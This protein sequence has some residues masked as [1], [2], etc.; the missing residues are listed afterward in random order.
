MLQVAIGVMVYNEAANLESLLSS[1]RRVR[2]PRLTLQQIV[3]VSSGSVDRSVPIA[4]EAA[5]RDARITVV[6]DP[7][8]RGKATAVNQFLDA[9]E[10][11]ID[12]C[13]LCGGDLQPDEHAI[14]R[15][16]MAF[17]DPSVGMAG[18]HPLPV[19]DGDGLV[20]RLVRLQWALHD[21][22]SRVRPKMGELI[23]FRADVPRLSPT[24]VVD[25]AYIE[26]MTT[27][28]G[29]RVV[30][31]PDAFVYNRGP[32]TWADLFEQR[33][34]I[35][36]GHLW[37]KKDTGYEVSTM[38]TRSLVLPVLEELF[39]NPGQWQALALAAPLELGAR[40]AGVVDVKVLKR[41][42]FVWKRVETTKGVINL[43]QWR[44]RAASSQKDRWRSAQSAQR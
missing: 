14:E 43:A 38:R 11:D 4:R 35:W 26:W 31:V 8:R 18:A 39:T 32:T 9:L 7:L 1:L 10:P 22:V 19:N 5:A 17:E 42:P 37:L 25:E 34:R 16:V 44:A 28:R 20:E 29:Q 2:G 40:L 13:V 27:H 21:R 3:V 36:A 41:N 23:A 12:V 24:T 15:L 6:D 33:R 30:Y